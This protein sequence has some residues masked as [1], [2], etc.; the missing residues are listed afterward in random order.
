MTEK[1]RKK[2]EKTLY[3]YIMLI[4]GICANNLVVDV[5]YESEL[6]MSIIK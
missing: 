4:T 2:S 5:I 3:S 1:D 6:K